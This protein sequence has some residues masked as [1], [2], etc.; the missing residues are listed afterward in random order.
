M[1]G[2]AFAQRR[3]R[4]PQRRPW[5]DWMVLPGLLAVGVV[6]AYPV[7][8]T[9]QLSTTEYN[10]LSGLDPRPVGTDNFEKLA[11]DPIFWEALG[12]TA[13]YTFG[14][15][16]VAALIGVVLALVTEDMVGRSRFLKTL[17]LTP[18]AV[19]FV[20]VAFLFRYMFDERT[21]IVNAVLTNM[22]V[23][24][25]GVP[26]LVSATWALPTVV[27]ANVW[28]QTPFFFLVFSAALAAI[29]NDVIEAARVDKTRGWTMARRIKLPYLRNAALVASLL[30]VIS[31]FND[32]AKI[33]AMTEGGPGYA[34]TTF[35]VWVYRLAFTSFDLGYSSAIG[36][37]WL[38]LL[39][40]FAIAYARLLRR[41]T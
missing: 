21:G 7:V 16:A 4:G 34:S 41:G 25:Q 31:N 1:R 24:D 22:G 15:V 28:T 38:L 30:M 11:Q 14:S 12:N 27:A 19:P 36:V 37:V 29:P 26:W 3:R 35:V 20:V 17:L 9:F 32:F 39:M 2:V 8:R 18:W 10:A 33:W 23:I 5:L 40:T 6:I 13:I